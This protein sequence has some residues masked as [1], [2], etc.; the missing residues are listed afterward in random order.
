MGERENAPTERHAGVPDL[1][2]PHYLS[3]RFTSISSELCVTIVCHRTAVFYEDTFG[4]AEYLNLIKYVY[5]GRQVVGQLVIFH[6]PLAPPFNGCQHAFTIN[7]TGLYRKLH[8]GEKTHTQADGHH[9]TSS[10]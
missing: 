3:I 2:P 5:F 4:G 10:V 7:I 6:G 9:T 8:Y 1:A